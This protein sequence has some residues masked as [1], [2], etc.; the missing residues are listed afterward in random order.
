MRRDWKRARLAAV[1]AG[2]L[3]V[4]ACGSSNPAGP[5]NPGAPAPTLTPP[6]PDNPDPDEQLS[7]LRPT[8]R[9]R[10]GTSTQTG[11]RTY[12]L[13]VAPSSDFSLGTISIAAIAEGSGTTSFTLQQDLQPTTRHFWRSR[14]TQGSTVSDWSVIRAFKTRLI[15]F[16]GS[17]ELYDPLIHGESLG[18]RIGS[19]TFLDGEG[20]RL[21]ALS[22]RVRY[23]L[24]ETLSEGEFSLQATG[25]DNDSDGES[26]KL[27]SMQQGATD[28]TENPYRATIE[29]R[30]N[31][32]VSFRLIGG[33][34]DT[35]AD[36]DRRI[37]QFNPSTTYYWKFTWG[38][39]VARLVITERDEQGQVVYNDADLYGG[40]YRP[41]PHIAH[42]GAPV[43]R[44]GLVDASTPGAIIRNVWI[45]SRPR[46]PELR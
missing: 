13:Q 18:Q 15:G 29:K 34:P 26:T 41:D 17:R 1:L 38:G 12:E 4:Q 2:A 24:L 42:L 22:S 32:T 36:A 6:V 20:L 45:S 14:M 5:S 16:R 25:L 28:I 21:N 3:V 8:F 37:V 7:T 39:G 27:F 40:T 35:R 30:A 43:P 31:G 10:N 46:P 33:N 44:G 19:T 11:A 9:V 23:E